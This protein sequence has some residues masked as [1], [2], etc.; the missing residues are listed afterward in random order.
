M[1]Y[2]SD[3][4]GGAPFALNVKMENVYAS[5]HDE[6]GTQKIRNDF[7]FPQEANLFSAA[8]FGKNFGAFGEI[9]FEDTP[10]GR[11]RARHRARPVRHR[12][13]VRPRE[14]GPL[15]GGEVRPQPLRRVPGDVDHDGQRD[16]HHLH[17]QPDRDQRRHGALGGGRDRPARP[18]ARDR[19]VRG[20]EAP[21]LLHG[22][23]GP[24]DRGRGAQRRLR[25][26]SQEGPLRAASTTSSGAWA[27]TATPAASTLPAENW[28][29]RSLRVG[30]ARLHRQ[31]HRRA[32]RRHR[33]DGHPLQDAG[34]PLQA[35]G[36]L[37]LRL[38][39]RPERLRRAPPRHGPPPAPRRGGPR[40][41]ERGQPLLQR[42]VRPGGL[43]DPPALPGVPAL[44]APDPGRRGRPRR[45]VPEWQ[46]HAS[47]CAPTSRPC[48]STGATSRTRR[49]TR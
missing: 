13:P 25:V 18:R 5:S 17:L 8:T 7:Q 48:S 16:R 39:R 10:D 9:T 34:R 45:Q 21:L 23:R 12:Q 31:R 14:P 15:P 42:L 4:P 32:L 36:R 47:W 33:R 49:T 6:S 20:G 37:R 35:R 2:P 1:V 22:R 26:N 3:L 43:R 24:D 11:H 30:R 41:R 28:R 29:E 40:A 27:S 19:D 46:L 44:R 38:L